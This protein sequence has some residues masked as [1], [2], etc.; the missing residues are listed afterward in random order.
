MAY[1]RRSSFFLAHK[2]K[3]SGSLPPDSS[4]K[5][6]TPRG[7]ARFLPQAL[8]F[9]ALFLGRVEGL[10]SRRLWFTKSHI[11]RSSP[12]LYGTRVR[13]HA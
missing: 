2:G 6:R 7:L 5:A 10:I 8:V 1:S 11:C 3:P 12:S 9:L 4:F 13:T